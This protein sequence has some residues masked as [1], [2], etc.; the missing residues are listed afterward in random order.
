MRIFVL[1]ALVLAPVL[2]FSQEAAWGNSIWTV[3]PRITDTTRMMPTGDFQIEAGLSFGF[4]GDRQNRRDDYGEVLL[5]YGIAPRLE[6]RV[7]LPTY[8]DWH[9]LDFLD[10]FGDVSVSLSY[11]LG[12][13][14]PV[15]FAVRPQLTIPT[16]SQ[17]PHDKDVSPAAFLTGEARLGKGFS[18]ASTLGYSHVEYDLGSLFF[19]SG[20]ANYDIFHA[21]FAV[22]RALRGRASVFAEYAGDFIHGVDP[23]HLAN[24]GGRLRLSRDSQ[25]DVHLT[26]PI[27]DTDRQS[28]VGVG[29]AIRF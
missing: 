10:G 15:Y 8:T 14:G 4:D 18:L 6:A 29:Y 27:G 5:R 28:S 21:T 22:E 9:P 16:G 17:Y 20:S 13:L 2:A 3:R 25:V 1:G 24:F 12:R 23:A 19:G 7:G 26:T 11:L